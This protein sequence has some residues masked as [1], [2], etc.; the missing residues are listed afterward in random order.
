MQTN[1]DPEIEL[2][3]T[4]KNSSILLMCMSAAE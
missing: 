4:F 1:L 2:V 3:G